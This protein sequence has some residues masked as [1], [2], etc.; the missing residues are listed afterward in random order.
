M[1]GKTHI[2]AGVATG[3][4]LGCNIPQ[5]VLVAFGAILCLIIID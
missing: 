1:T 4:L 2:A 5:I 3:I